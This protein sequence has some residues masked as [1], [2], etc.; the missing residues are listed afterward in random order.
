MAGE[1]VAVGSRVTK[2]KKGDRV[3]SNFSLTHLD[4]E[5]SPDTIAHALGAPIHGVLTEYKAF[6]EVVRFSHCTYYIPL[7]IY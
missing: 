2:W 5:P 4:G 1:V 6:P 3:C 7:T